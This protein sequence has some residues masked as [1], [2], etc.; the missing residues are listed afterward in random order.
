VKVLPRVS[1]ADKSG[2][3]DIFGEAHDSNATNCETHTHALDNETV[4]L[5]LLFDFICCRCL[6]VAKVHLQ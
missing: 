6:C 2:T 4:C 3:I 5:G 1:E